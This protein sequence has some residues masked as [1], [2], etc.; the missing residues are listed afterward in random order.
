MATP[1][2]GEVLIGAAFIALDVIGEATQSHFSIPR[3]IRWHMSDLFV[4]GANA[5]I[6]NL[7]QMRFTKKSYPV[8]TAL[9]VLAGG[10]YM[11]IEQAK[12]RHHSFDWID[13]ACYVASTGLYIEASRRNTRRC[14]RLQKPGQVSH[15]GP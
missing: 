7:G 15:P 5:A 6:I 14:L 12:T 2:A 4:V 1:I 10:T 9:L 3:F 8:L 13:E 11:E